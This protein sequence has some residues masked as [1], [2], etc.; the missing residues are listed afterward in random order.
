MFFLVQSPPYKGDSGQF[1]FLFWPFYGED[2]HGRLCV[3]LCKFLEQGISWDVGFFLF[4]VD[5]KKSR[6]SWNR[7]RR[8][9]PPATCTNLLVETERRED[10]KG[11]QKEKS[12]ARSCSSHPA[13]DG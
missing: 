7:S 13:W 9:C 3:F 10:V 1:L 8:I 12:G 6:Y 5:T 11:E 4:G 2:S